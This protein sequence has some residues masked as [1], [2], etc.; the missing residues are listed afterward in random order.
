MRTSISDTSQYT[1]ICRAAQSD[2]AAFRD[3][4]RHPAYTEILEHVSFDLGRRYLQIIEA[5]YP[6]LLPYFDRFKINDQLGNPITFDY[7][8]YGKFSPTTLRY[9]K[10][11]GDIITKFGLTQATS[12]VE[13]G[14][15]YGGQCV[16]INQYIK[17]SAYVIYDLPDVVGLQKKYLG[18]LAVEADARSAITPCNFDLCIS[19]YAFSECDKPV[20]D[21]YLDGVISKSRCGYML[22]N[23]VSDLF[24]LRSHT[25]AELLGRIAGSNQEE[26]TPFVFKGNK[27]IWWKT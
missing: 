22:C 4:K 3:F 7:G 8:K 11:L 12:I 18:K 5:S 1:A 9:I 2:D 19:N 26:E 10:I 13:I 17:P 15:G 24:N 20:Q 21:Q 27:L 6:F 14:G 23:F 16:V 25:A